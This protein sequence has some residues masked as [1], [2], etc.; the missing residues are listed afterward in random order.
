MSIDVIGNFLT[1]IRNGLMRS[2]PHVVVP[3]SRHLFE[4]AG[5]LEQEG[6]IKGIT[7][8][9]S[10]AVKKTM[11][12]VLKY[13]DGQ[14][15]IHELT[16]TSKPGR[17]VYQKTTKLAPVIGNLGVSILSTSKGIM[18]NKKAKELRA[19]GEVLCTVW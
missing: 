3:Y 13:V 5:V 17:R 7:V 16:R 11:K 9:E 14:S 10:D 1:T 8:D 4:I 18:T 12:I 6:F 2:Q 15:V 19:G